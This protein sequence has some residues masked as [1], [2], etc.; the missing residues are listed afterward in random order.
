MYKDEEKESSGRRSHL[1]EG[2]VTRGKRKSQIGLY[3]VLGSTLSRY[4]LDTHEQLQG[5]AGNRPNPVAS[6]AVISSSLPLSW[7]SELF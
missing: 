1:G 3:E 7:N 2:P 6:G 4:H 5:K